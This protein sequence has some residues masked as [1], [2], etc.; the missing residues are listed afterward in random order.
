[1]AQRRMFSLQI[2][3]TDAFL[4]M[5]ITSQLLYFHLS[6]RAD[7]DG[8]VANPKKI[9]RIIGTQEDDMKILIAKRFIISFDNGIIVIKHWKIH[10]YIQKDRYKETKYLEQKATLKTKE[11]GSYTECIQNGYKLD[12]QVRVGKGRLGKVNNLLS[13]KVDNKS[14]A[15]DKRNPDIETVYSLFE[16][17]LGIRPKP[18]K[19]KNGFDLNRGACHRLIKQHGVA[20]LSK[21]LLLVFQH[22]SKD[23]YCRTSTNPLDFEKNLAWYK[24]Y[25]D[26][27]RAE[28]IKAQEG[29]NITF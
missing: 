1:M 21:M 12:T 19:A 16:K 26:K 20:N 15:P 28:K 29:N 11:N 5:P 6:M 14:K 22:Q 18:I 25:F 8:F 4:D 23:R 13:T 17:H 27:K 24:T 3:D 7:D 9:M 10:N 2:V